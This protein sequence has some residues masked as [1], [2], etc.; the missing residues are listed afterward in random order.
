MMN[1]EAISAIGEIIG[2]I[3][4][5][6]TLS[7][8]ARQIKDSTR[9]SRSQSITDAT[10]GMQAWYQELGSNP[11]A[12]ELILKGF[13]NPEALSKEAQFQ[14]LMMLHAFL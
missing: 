9:A 12:S 7:Y 14:W 1:W 2:A 10:T 4:V 13:T 8:L 6:A 3:T 5:V 11:Q